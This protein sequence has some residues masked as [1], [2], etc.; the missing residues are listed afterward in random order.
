MFYAF[1]S[2]SC[3]RETDSWKFF[4]PPS[5]PLTTD[6]V[7]YCC[8]R[9]NTQLR[10]WKNSSLLF[11]ISGSDASV[12]IFIRHSTN[13]R[14][15]QQQQQ[16]RQTFAETKFL[17]DFTKQKLYANKKTNKTMNQTKKICEWR[18]REKKL[19]GFGFNWQKLNFWFHSVWDKKKLHLA[20]EFANMSLDTSTSS[21]SS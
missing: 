4:F 3:W 14:Q 15:Q 17:F 13:I 12:T 16:Q 11:S 20:I 7:L 6:A 8:C 2:F 19:H 9:T 10:C 21:S 5:N 1:S 18:T